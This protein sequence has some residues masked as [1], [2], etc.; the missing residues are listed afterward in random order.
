MKNKKIIFFALLGLMYSCQNGA[1]YTCKKG[2][3]EKY[4]AYYGKSWHEVKQWICDEGEY[5]YS[6]VKQSEPLFE[7]QSEE[8]RRNSIPR[9]ISEEEAKDCD[10]C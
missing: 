4:R 10:G 9:E 8:Q 1:T 2:H 3:Y 5:D 7:I 6:N